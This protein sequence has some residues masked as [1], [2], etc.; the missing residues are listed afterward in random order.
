MRH[1]CLD[2]VAGKEAAGASVSTE[3]ETH[4]LGV[5]RGVLHFASALGI[6]FSELGEA[7]GVIF[8]RVRVDFGVHGDGLGGNADG[9]VGRDSEAVGHLIVHVDHTFHGDWMI[10]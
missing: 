1:D 8:F 3:A 5:G 6:H 10:S 4:A 7:E 2:L 9:G